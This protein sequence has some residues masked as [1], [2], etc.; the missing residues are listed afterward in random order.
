M[1]TV[2][3]SWKLIENKLNDLIIKSPNCSTPVSLVK[4][5]SATQSPFLQFFHNFVY[6]LLLLRR[7]FLL[8]VSPGENF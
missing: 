2:W 5:S 1:V 4:Q 7:L 8:N 3:A 6:L